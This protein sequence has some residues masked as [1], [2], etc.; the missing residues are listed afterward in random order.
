LAINKFTNVAVAV[1]DGNTIAST[2]IL[3]NTTYVDIGS[4][5][6][7]RVYW[8]TPTATGN[9]VDYYQIVIDSYDISTLTTTSVF[10]GSV[11]N[12]N[13]FYITSNLLSKISKS[14][15]QLRIKLVAKSL[16]GASYDGTSSTAIVDVCKGCGTYVKVTDGYKQPIMKRVLAFT[17]LDYFPLKDTEGLA[18]L[19]AN[20]EELYVKSARSQDTDAGWAL[21]QN[22][23][24]KNPSGAWKQSDISYEVLTNSDGEI[25]T[26]VNNDPIYTL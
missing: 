16:Y 20:G 19:D 8:P 26:D 18:L 11:G 14:K 22:F 23:Y 12:V 3:G 1:A 7:L 17:K 9:A 10:N 13:E 21:M 5:T 24:S 2:S 6:V 25:I 4:G 15:Y